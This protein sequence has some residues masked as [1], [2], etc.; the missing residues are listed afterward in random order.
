MRDALAAKVLGSIAE[1]EFLKV[2]CQRTAWPTRRG[3]T[4]ATRHLTDLSA[5]PNQPA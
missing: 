5:Y 4:A 2:R 1:L 3:A